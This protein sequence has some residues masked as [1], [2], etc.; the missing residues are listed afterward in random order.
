MVHLEVAKAIR[1]Q[2]GMDVEI[3]PVGFHS[4]KKQMSPFQDR[5]EMV[6]RGIAG[7]PGLSVNDLENRLP[8]PTRT[9]QTL[10]HLYPD[11]D[12][13]AEIHGEKIPFGLGLDVL[14]NL[15]AWGPEAKIL[16]RNLKFFVAPR[17]QA[18]IPDK[19]MFPDEV[20]PIDVVVVHV[21]DQGMSSTKIRNRVAAGQPI[22]GMVPPAVEQ[23]IQQKGL[24][25]SSPSTGK[26]SSTTLAFA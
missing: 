21:S 17:G 26:K 3:F 1:D 6:K 13:Y 20:I 23:Y 25:Q 22:R 24:Y 4:E 18:P 8:F 19:L 14:L 11:F 5:F 2:S 15:P 12:R 7:E 10:R 9:I 16:A